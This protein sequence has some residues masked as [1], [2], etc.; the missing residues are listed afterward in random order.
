MLVETLTDRLI[1][2]PIDSADDAI[3]EALFAIQSN[4]ATWVHLP[5][6]VEVEIS[7][8]RTIAED[9]ARSWGN[10]GLGW[11]MLRLRE[12][13]GTLDAGAVIGLGGAAVRRPEVPAWNLGY[14]LTPA[15]WGHGLAGE[16]SRAAVTAANK[17]QPN[18]PVTARALTHN[19][20]SWHTL[21]RAGLT[22]A[23]EGNAP[24]EY[25]LTSGVQRRIYTDRDLTPALLNQLILLG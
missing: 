4:P 14:R 18:L 21:E 12:P 8:S 9:Y 15:V 25:A 3:V 23:W 1:L 19:P 24:A 7:Q 5:D 16:A 17:A 6:G 13:L 11:W 20:A 22:L 10:F 2:T